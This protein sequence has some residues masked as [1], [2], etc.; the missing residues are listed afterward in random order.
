MG[1]VGLRYPSFHYPQ[2]LRRPGSIG[3]HLCMLA[4]FDQA[5]WIRVG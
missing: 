1:R 2:V 3:H 5:T 4:R